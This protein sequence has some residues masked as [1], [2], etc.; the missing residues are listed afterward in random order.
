MEKAQESGVGKE[1]GNDSNTER[2]GY[3][4]ERDEE[5]G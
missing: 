1:Q 4:L 3:K 2:R 5:K